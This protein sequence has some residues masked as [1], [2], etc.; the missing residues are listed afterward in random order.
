MMRV[1]FSHPAGGDVEFDIPP[2]GATVGRQGGEADLQLGGDGTMSRRHGRLWIEG[3]DLWY[4]DLGSSQGSWVQK[5]RVRAP[6]KVVAGQPVVLGATEMVLLGGAPVMV[7]PGLTLQMQG[8]TGREALVEAMAG[9]GRLG[10]YTS[11]LYDFVQGLLSSTSTDLIS[12]A[13]SRLYNLVPAAQRIALVAW[14]PFEDGTFEHLVPPEDL[15]RRGVQAGPVS[16]SL[17]R[18]AVET[19]KALLFSDGGADSEMKV[20]ASVMHH[21]I[22]SA[23]YVPLAS[24]SGETLAVLCVDC[25]NPSIPF[26]KEDFQFIGA[27]GGLLATALATEELRQAALSARESEARRQAMVSFLKIASHDLKNPLA[28]IKTCAATILDL[29]DPSIVDELTR[30]ILNAE[31]RAEELIQAYLQVSALQSGKQLEVVK[32]ELD[33]RDM[34]AQEIEF[35]KRA[36]EGRAFTFGSTVGVPRVEADPQ[37]LRQVLANLIGN[38]VKYSPDGG[39][40]TVDVSRSNGE[41]LFR[42]TDTG[43]GIT[44]EDQ[45]KLFGEFQRVG[46]RSVAA[47][48]GL[49]L[50]LTASLVKAHGGRIGVESEAGRGSTFWFTVP[51]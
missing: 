11:A 32:Q 24:A 47:G 27:V 10:R 15:V 20:G 42:V 4:E 28:V 1:R 30:L 46:D 16:Q 40:V 12:Q 34:V 39:A 3:G 33:L 44:P 49:G 9:A 29:Q 18:H 36:A 21:G 38:A 31:R 22:R 14:P 5:Q 13:L 8:A 35:Q 48:T 23:V 50:W 6:V 26:S 25:P 37:K 41:V 45:A 19:G 2:Q 17:A 43:V 51:G 7:A